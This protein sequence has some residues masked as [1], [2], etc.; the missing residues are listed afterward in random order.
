VEGGRTWNETEHAL[1]VF[2]NKVLRVIFRRKSYEVTKN[3][4]N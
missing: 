2:E 4:R 3:W 1:R